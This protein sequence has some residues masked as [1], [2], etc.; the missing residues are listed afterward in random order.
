M[1]TECVCLILR[2][3]DTLKLRGLATENEVIVLSV[4]QASRSIAHNA[5]HH[6]H[7]RMSSIRHIKIK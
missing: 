3:C 7:N 1:T 2:M 6:V 4:S 5:R